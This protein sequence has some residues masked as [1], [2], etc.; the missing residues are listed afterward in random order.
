MKIV[1]QCAASKDPAAGYFRSQDG[2]P[3]KFVAAP[4]KAPLGKDFLYFCPDDP[5]HVEGESWRDLVLHYNQQPGNNPLGLVP[6]YQLYSNPTYGQL[7]SSFGVDN[8]YI[9][10]AGWGLISARFLT[11]QYDITFSAS[12]EG[13]KRRKHRDPYL[14]FSHLD[15]SG[16]EPVLFFGGKDYL[17]LFCK[18]TE[19]AGN[20]R[21]VFFNSRSLPEAPSCRLERYRTTMRTNWH[22]ACAQDF[23]S[24]KITVASL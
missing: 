24:G 14:D 8:V 5:S 6:A 4:E 1:I 11:P 18:L 20:Q 9:L 17:P 10:S 21:I 7:V 2:R 3:I 16:S 19:A 15:T 12:A 13:F 23:L 22:Y